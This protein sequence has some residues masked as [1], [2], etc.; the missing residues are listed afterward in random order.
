MKL[1][2]KLFKSEEKIYTSNVELIQKIIINN[3]ND[4]NDNIKKL[5][6]TINEKNYQNIIKKIKIDDIEMNSLIIS[7]NTL[8]IYT[9]SNIS[10][11]KV[12]IESLKNTFLNSTDSIKEGFIY[13]IY[14]NYIFISFFSDLFKEYLGIEEN[15]IINGNYIIVNN[16]KIPIKNLD[17]TEIKTKYIN[18]PFFYIKSNLLY[19]NGFISPEGE[20]IYL[21]DINNIL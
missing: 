13:L 19:L 14:G 3:F 11:N 16:E 4:S 15:T 8:L 10:I 12:E 1:L 21:W 20:M 6:S 18:N 2:K 7:K 17:E 5:I 9:N